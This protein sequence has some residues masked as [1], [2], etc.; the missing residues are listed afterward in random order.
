[1]KP[2]TLKPL[3]DIGGRNV[4]FGAGQPEYLPLPAWTDGKQVIECW[5]LTWRDRL[6]ALLGGDLFVHV[7]TFGH[8][9][10]PIIVTFDWADI[11][12]QPSEQGDLA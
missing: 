7:L 9:I 3:R 10:Q 2:V 11:D 4:V 1:M 5:R 6:R 12:S 8:P